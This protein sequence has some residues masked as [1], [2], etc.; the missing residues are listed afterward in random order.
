MM[1]V[2][3]KSAMPQHPGKCQ[4]TQYTDERSQG[5]SL[6]RNATGMKFTHICAC[7]CRLFWK[8]VL[9]KLEE[10]IW[11]SE[12]RLLIVGPQPPTMGLC[13]SFKK[14]ES[15]SCPNFKTEVLSLGL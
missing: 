9:V 8:L 12:G 5:K 1:V 13:Y 7:R 14:V 3:E 10:G 11:E 6:V 2:V 4:A 15:G